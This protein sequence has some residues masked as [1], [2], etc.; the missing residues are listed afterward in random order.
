M[1]NAPPSRQRPATP[2]KK[3]PMRQP[4]ENQ[5]MH[6][7]PPSRQRPASPNKKSPIRQRPASPFKKMPP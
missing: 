2:N 1:P 5:P 3:S 7:A 4:P 6:N